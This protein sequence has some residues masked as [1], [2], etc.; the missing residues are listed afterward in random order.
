M[1]NVMCQ[2]ATDLGGLHSTYGTH[3]SPIHSPRPASSEE[4]I[5]VRVRVRQYVDAVPEVRQARSVGPDLARLP[6][7][8]VLDCY[9]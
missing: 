7:G 6:I 1:P 4:P 8:S 9:L 5:H 3:G 2:K